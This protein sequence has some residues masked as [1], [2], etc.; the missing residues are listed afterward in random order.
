MVKII[1]CL[2]AEEVEMK[3]YPRTVKLL[4]ALIKEKFGPQI[5][6]RNKSNMPAH[7]IWMMR[8]MQNFPDTR[9]GSAKSGRWIGWILREM[10]NQGIIGESRSLDELKSDVENGDC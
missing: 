5:P 7:L 9:D 3:Y 10:E 6:E 1:Q 8:E 2:Q 4:T